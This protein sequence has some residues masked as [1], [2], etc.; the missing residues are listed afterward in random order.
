[1]TVHDFIYWIYKYVYL[2]RVNTG[3]SKISREA[4]ITQPKNQ[5]SKKIT[6]TILRSRIARTNSKLEIFIGIVDCRQ[7]K[8][9]SFSKS[10]FYQLHFQAKLSSFFLSTALQP[11][12]PTASERSCPLFPWC[13]A[14]N[15]LHF[16]WDLGFFKGLKC[17]TQIL[18]VRM[19]FPFTKR[20]HVIFDCKMPISQI[21]RC[22]GFLLR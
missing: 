1:M 5:T 2:S 20:L 10:L 22:S 21:R 15:D 18:E 12:A 14:Q 4:V 16:P 8:S 19:Y 6:F 11:H 3:I 7:R 17:Q 13:P 9:L